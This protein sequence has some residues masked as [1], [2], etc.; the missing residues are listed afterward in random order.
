MTGAHVVAKRGQQ[1]RYPVQKQ[2]E[3]NGSRGDV[4]AGATGLRESD[5]IRA[6][7]DTAHDQQSQPA[8]RGSRQDGRGEGQVRYGR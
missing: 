7:V 5:G 8:V 2:G 1:S 6:H 4:R 3:D